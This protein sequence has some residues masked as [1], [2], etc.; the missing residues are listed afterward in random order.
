MITPEHI[1]RMH[2]VGLDKA[3]QMLRVTTQKGIRTAVHPIHKR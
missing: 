1:A 2:N 3:K